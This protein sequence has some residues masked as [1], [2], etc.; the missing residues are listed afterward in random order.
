MNEKSVGGIVFRKEE[1]RILYLLL[2]Y[3]RKNDEKG[4]HSYWDFPKGHIEKGESEEE[5]LRRE[6]KEETSI[7]DA[8]I[9]D[10][11]RE[12]INYF[13]RKNGKLVRKEVVFYLCETMQKRAKVSS[14]HKDARWLDYKEAMKILAFENAKEILGKANK[15]LSKKTLKNF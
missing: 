8:R 14:E 3:E 2:L 11:F 1:K 5:T 13:F 7:S 15:F 12:K 9:I 4:E 10:G 6:V